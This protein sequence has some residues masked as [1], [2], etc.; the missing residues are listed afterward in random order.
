[1]NTFQEGFG[2]SSFLRDEIAANGAYSAKALPIIK[3]C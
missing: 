3:K 2:K 1:M